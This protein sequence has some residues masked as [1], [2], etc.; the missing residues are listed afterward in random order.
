MAVGHPD[1]YGPSGSLTLNHQHGLRY[2]PR[3]QASEATDFNTEKGCCKAKDPDMA[4][5]SSLGLNVTMIPGGSEDLLDQN[6]PYGNTSL[7]H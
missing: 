6:G 3:L 2:Q 7:G 1:V 4:I 5:G